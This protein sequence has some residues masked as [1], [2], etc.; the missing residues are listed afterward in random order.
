LFDVTELAVDAAAQR[1]VG[2]AEAGLMRALAAAQEDGMLLPVH[3][4]VA[5]AALV[6]ARALDQAEAHG[7]PKTPYAVQAAMPS[8]L[9]ACWALGIPV[10]VSPVPSASKPLPAPEPADDRPDWLRDAFGTPE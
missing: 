2:R 4:G 7:G 8:L 1:R 5:G 10:K 3:A 6:A 9:E